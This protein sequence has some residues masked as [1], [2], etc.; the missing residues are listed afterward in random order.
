MGGIALCRI[1][2]IEQPM[3]A[4]IQFVQ[5][6]E[7]SFD[8]GK[9]HYGDVGLSQDLF[10]G[11]VWNIVSR[12]LKDCPD[13]LVIVDFTRRLFLCDLYLTCGCVYKSER[14]WEAFDR[15][16][17]RFVADLVRF[18]YRHGTEK[19][20]VADSILV[21]LFLPDRSGRQRIASYDG[22]SSLATWLRVI[23]VN[24]AIN[25]R[26]ERK[27]ACDE[28]VVD[29]PDGRAIL[30]IQSAVHAERYSKALTESINQAF[31]TLNPRER[32]MLLWRYEDNLQLGEIAK[33]LGIHQSNVTRQ[34]LR[35][36]ARLRESVIHALASQHH[37]SPLAIQECLT[38]IVANPNISISLT[39]L[40][41]PSPT[42]VQASPSTP[43]PTAPYRSAQGR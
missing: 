41:Q 15:R 5:T 2:A 12:H 21:S 36:Q 25:E 38:D 33:L 8:D 24:R 32:L 39:K 18:C 4:P 13:D 19:E 20:E 22:R 28:T 37:L 29:I 11:Y 14:A 31:Q 7:Q 35:L 34:L 6:V 3:S 16:Y 26:N 9:S 17:R 40:I 23:V 30:N 43:P 42:M 27:V 1:R 10:T